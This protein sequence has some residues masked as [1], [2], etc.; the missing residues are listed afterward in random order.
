LRTARLLRLGGEVVGVV[1]RT[2]CSRPVLPLS[3]RVGWAVGSPALVAHGAAP[4]A[5][6]GGG[7]G[8][9][10][11]LLLTGAPSSVNGT[12]CGARHQL[13]LRTVAAFRRG[14]ARTGGV[15]QDLL[16]TVRGPLV[17]VGRVR[18]FG[19]GPVTSSCCARES[20]PQVV[21]ASKRMVTSSCCARISPLLR[22]GR[23]N[24][25]HRLRSRMP[26]ALAATRPG[27]RTKIRTRIAIAGRRHAGGTPS[28]VVTESDQ[29]ESPSAGSYVINCGSRMR[30]SARM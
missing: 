29:I 14:T 3:G 27:S 30:E 26:P 19:S 6:C 12:G 4:S 15:H 22:A 24:S 21:T 1:T 10:Q 13:L 7:R 18:E 5:R 17:V 16:R 8:G 25:C 9:H 23:P 2:C 20:P 28:G 11:D